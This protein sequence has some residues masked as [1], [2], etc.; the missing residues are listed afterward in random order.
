MANMKLQ[1]IFEKKSETYEMDRSVNGIEIDY[2]G[3]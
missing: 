2:V 3:K 1:V